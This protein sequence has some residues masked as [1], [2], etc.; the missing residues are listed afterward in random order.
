MESESYTMR[1]QKQRPRTTVTLLPDHKAVLA[2]IAEDEDN[3]LLSR[4]LQR[5]LEREG[6]SRL[7]PDWRKKIRAWSKEQEAAATV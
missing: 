5:I 2:F 4:S 3:G 1:V 7:G 6:E